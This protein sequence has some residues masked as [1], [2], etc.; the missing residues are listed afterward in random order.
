MH[1]EENIA[2]ARHA[3]TEAGT[4]PEEALPPD[5]VGGPDQ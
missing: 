3:V 1:Q 2:G 4:L 5:A